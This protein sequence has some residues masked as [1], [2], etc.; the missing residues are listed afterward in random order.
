MARLSA[1]NSAAASS[2]NGHISAPSI[3]TSAGPASLLPS[4]SHSNVGDSKPVEDDNIPD[5]DW[6]DEAV[7][8][9]PLPMD[10]SLFPGGT[11]DLSYIGVQAFFLGN[12]FAAG[13][14]GTITTIVLG[15]AWWRLSAFATSLAL[16]HFL[17][18][19]T[20]ARYNTPAL[21]AE[22]F[23][24]FNNGRAYQVAHG[25]ATLELIVSRF[26]PQYGQ[27]FVNPLTIALGIAL[28]I[29][30]QLVRSLAMAQAGPSFNHVIAREHKE[31]H[32]LVTHG[33]YSIFRHPSY[34]GFFWWAIGTQ[35]LVGNKVCLV[36]YI[37]VLWQFFSRRIQGEEKFLVNFFGDKYIEYKKKT[38]TKIPL[39]R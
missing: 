12:V 18:Y 8:T 27:T 34:F 14:S 13:I 36:G 25:C 16:F 6:E 38:G 32:K 4:T 5:T 11:R 3:A 24:L 33:L 20:T 17:E 28:I 19:F 35:F 22:S 1:S 23:L 29:V 30:G 2:A 7:D 10:D 15:S 37:I 21:R 31:H 39:I 9:A 26:L